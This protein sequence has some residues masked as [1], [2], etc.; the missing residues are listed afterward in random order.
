[1]TIDLHLVAT[2]L[3]SG[4]LSDFPVTRLANNASCQDP[5][6]DR[7]EFYL[8]VVQMLQPRKCTFQKMGR[9]RFISLESVIVLQ[10]SQP[11]TTGMKRTKKTPG[12]PAK[13]VQRLLIGRDTCPT[14]SEPP[15]EL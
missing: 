1:M 11:A 12:Q 5:G 10:D 7:I 6:T 8:L 2:D 14:L 3:E 13:W 9:S 4:Y 15:C